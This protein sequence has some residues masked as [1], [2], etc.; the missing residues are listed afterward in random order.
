MTHHL[1]RSALDA[2]RNE[3]SRAHPSLPAKAELMKQAKAL[4]ALVAKLPDDLAPAETA[5][6][7]VPPAGSAEN[8]TAAAE[9]ETAAAETTQA[10]TAAAE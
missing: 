8:A 10:E 4:I 6:P 7:E 2:L 9:G 5:A 1:V 3:F